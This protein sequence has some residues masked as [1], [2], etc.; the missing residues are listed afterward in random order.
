MGPTTINK[1]SIILDSYG[2][3]YWVYKIIN[4]L[5]FC[6]DRVRAHIT[7][8]YWYCE[9]YVSSF[10]AY[11]NKIISIRIF[12][13][14]QQ[15]LIERRFLRIWKTI[16]FLSRNLAIRMNEDLNTLKNNYVCILANSDCFSNV[17]RTIYSFCIEVIQRYFFSKRFIESNCTRS[18]KSMKNH[19]KFVGNL[20][21]AKQLRYKHDTLIN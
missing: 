8:S 11:Y 1:W 3:S 10:T 19:F 21:N 12:N 16:I 18:D 2:T 5:L 20:K 14:L 6:L 7:F 4:S 17:K 13:F 15:Q 9:I